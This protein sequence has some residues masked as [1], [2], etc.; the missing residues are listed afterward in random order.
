MTFDLLVE[1]IQDDPVFT[2]ESRNPQMPVE[3]Q[4]AIALYRFGRN[5]NGVILQDV[6]WW[7]GVAKGSVC[8]V[9]KRVLR[10]VTQ[11]EF[12]QSVVKLPKEEEKEAEKR[13]V[14]QKSCR[15]WRDG[16]CLVDGTLVPLF[17]KPFW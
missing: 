15:A 14:E 10:A 4:L 8:N 12:I 7:A 5:G 1:A 17:E 6:S 3:Q 13:W 16:W 2:N 9:T 11:T